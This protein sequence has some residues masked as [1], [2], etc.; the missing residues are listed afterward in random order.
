MSV[1]RSQ[2][3]QFDRVTLVLP[4]EGSP[5]LTQ[6]LVYTAV[7]RA[8]EHVRIIGTRAALFAA[9]QRPIQRASGLRG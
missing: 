3:S 6:E 7:T 9:A 1:H 4:P 2:G 5:L 8:K